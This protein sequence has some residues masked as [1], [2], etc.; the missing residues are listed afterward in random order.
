M[1]PYLKRR[2]D[3]I[4]ETI[5]KH[6]F[7][8]EDMRVA[9]MGDKI[10]KIQKLYVYLYPFLHMSHHGIQLAYQFAYLIGKTRYHSPTMH[11]LG[12]IVRR[13]T[14]EDVQ[15]NDP[16]K[17]SIGGTLTPTKNTI[18]PNQYTDRSQEIFT[19][20]K[21]VIMVGMTSALLLGWMGKLRQEIQRRRRLWWIQNY[22]SPSFL[23][24]I[25]EQEWDDNN[26]HTS[27]HH[28]SDG[29]YKKQG[30]AS[31]IPPPPPRPPSTT[32]MTKTDA[33]LA[34]A[35]RP[36]KDYRLCPICHETRINPAASSSGFVFCFKCLVVHI[37]T[38][39]PKCPVTGLACQESQIVRLYEPSHVRS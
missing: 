36:N 26:N 35:V 23:A 4:Y 22:E 15:K 30:D 7:Q 25:P 8:Q 12:Q 34:G 39:G 19:K 27:F 6:T 9:M 24:T 10:Q 11:L 18:L 5:R 28:N 29:H 3:V 13:I 20:F 16:I 17:Q 14:L 1:G 37:R 21:K 32:T 2:L 38:Y 33:P 31:M